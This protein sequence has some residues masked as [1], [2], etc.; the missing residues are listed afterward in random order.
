MPTAQSTLA[1]T[2][3]G[4][5]KFPAEKHMVHGTGRHHVHE[6]PHSPGGALEKLGRGVYK[7]TIQGNFQ[8]TFPA[9]PD[10]YPNGMNT[11]RSYFEQ[12][13]TKPFVHPSI[14][15]F[16]AMIIGWTQV[17]DARILSGEKVD[18]ELVED[19][20]AQFALADLVSSTPSASSIGPSA[21][22]VA[23]DL[24]SVRAQLALSQNDL[25][26]FD[27]IQSFAS[28]I[29]AIGDTASLYGNLYSTKI[30]AL[31]GVCSS[32]ES[33]FS[34]QDPRA[35]PVVNSILTLW[36]GCNQALQDVLQNQAQLAYYTVPITEPMS[37]IANDIYNDATRAGDL[38]G[39]N[40]TVVDAFN[41][42]AGTRIA[43]YP[44][45]T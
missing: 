14:G 3:F 23:A 13:L 21:A 15:K 27:A 32:L 26:L 35:W 6:Y 17:K 19:Q 9:Y 24:A 40:P 16:P 12:Q 22:Q 41:V 10:L 34:M 42:P 28:D 1:L 25:G 2:Q 5:I 38:L 7:F 33:S 30:Q 29:A 4:D 37:M 11:L 31:A 20:A 43:Y 39:L 8:A 36:Q 45:Q 44:V 18:I